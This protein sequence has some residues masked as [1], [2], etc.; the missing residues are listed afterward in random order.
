MA[1]YGPF[2]IEALDPVSGKLHVVRV[3]P[4]AIEAAG[5]RSMGQALECAELVPMVLQKPRHIWRGL[6]W[7]GDEKYSDDPGWLSYC[8][9]P[10][11]SYSDEGIRKLPRPNKVFMV[12]VNSE[13]V[14]YRWWW[15]PCDPE[16]RECPKDYE[17]RF[18]EQ[19]L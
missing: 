10:P 8:K 11:Y 9:I 19:L 6:R 13:N 5:R 15:V 3:S 18:R 7:E 1:G 17:V 12:C 2:A 16:D 14:V 4:K